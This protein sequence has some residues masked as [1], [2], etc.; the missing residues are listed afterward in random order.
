MCRFALYLGEPIR[1]GSL[2]TDPEFSILAQSYQSKEGNEP[3]N[4][5]GYGVAW[6]VAED[7]PPAVLKE[8]QPAWNSINLK[9]IAAVTRSGCLMA[10][11][12]AATKGLPVTQLNCHPFQWERLTLMHNGAI[13]GFA[14]IKRRLL[15]ALS[16]EAYAQIQGSADTEVLFAFVQDAWRALDPATPAIDR[17]TSALRR[18]IARV[19]AIRVGHGGLPPSA[20]NVALCDGDHAVVS[21]YA[22]PDGGRMNSLYVRSARTFD[23]LECGPDGTGFDERATIVASEPL[24]GDDGWDRVPDNHLVRVIRGRRFELVPAEIEPPA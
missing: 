13:G 14:K 21:R 24:T 18:A 16:D 10:H 17:L 9:S 6:Y 11:V 7:L 19:E 20:Y 22:S 15:A 12:R 3:L 1:I 2:V 23:C 8:V 5:D 4:G